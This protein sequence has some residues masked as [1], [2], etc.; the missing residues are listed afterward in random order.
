MS[1]DHLVSMTKEQRQEFKKQADDRFAEKVKK[2]ISENKPTTGAMFKL[3]PERY[4]RTWLDCFNGEANKRKAIA[5]KCY[6]CVG[7]ED[8][9]NNVGL[10]TARTCPLWNYRPIKK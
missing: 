4:K 7:Y 1:A 10:C 9:Q 2:F 5:A 6:E 8:T 3:I